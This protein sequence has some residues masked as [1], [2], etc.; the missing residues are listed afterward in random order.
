LP[1]AEPGAQE[2]QNAMNKV[3]PEHL[4]SLTD[5]TPIRRIA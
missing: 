2:D 1:T 4:A 3:T 5:S